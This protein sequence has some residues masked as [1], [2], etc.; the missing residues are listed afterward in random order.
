MA[1]YSEDLRQLMW[2]LYRAHPEAL[3]KSTQ[4]GARKMTDWVFENKAGW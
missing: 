4:V 1:Q 2:T 3:T